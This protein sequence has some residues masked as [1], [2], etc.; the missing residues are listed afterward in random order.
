MSAKPSAHEAVPGV[1]GVGVYVAKYATESK[2]EIG[3]VTRLPFVKGIRQFAAA[4][5]PVGPINS[6]GDLADDGHLGVRSTY[7]DSHDGRAYR[8]PSRV[9]KLSREEPAHASA[10]ALGANTREVLDTTLGYST[11]RMDELAR[12]GVI[13]P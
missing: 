9:P 10:P 4:D 5:L 7:W 8:Q 2:S 13:G 12:A 1:M 3:P 11:L 6:M